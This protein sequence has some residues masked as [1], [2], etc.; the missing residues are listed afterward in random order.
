MAK[1]KRNQITHKRRV[2]GPTQRRKTSSD[3]ARI[4]STNPLLLVEWA[5][6]RIVVGAG[7]ALV[8]LAVVVAF[9]GAATIQ[10]LAA[11][12]AVAK[13]GATVRSLTNVLAGFLK[14]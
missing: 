4:T 2:G 1:R 5:D 10:P 13:S 8:L 6:R 12:F 14:R 3:A 7:M 11:F 9:G